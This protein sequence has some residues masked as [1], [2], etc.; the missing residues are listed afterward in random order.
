MFLYMLVLFR[1][2]QTFPVQGPVSAVVDSDK[3]TILGDTPNWPDEPTINIMT[4]PER[5]KAKVL[6]LIWERRQYEGSV[7][8]FSRNPTCST[9]NSPQDFGP[10]KAFTQNDVFGSA[11]DVDQG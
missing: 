11:G 1:S 9:Q 5:Q 8:G 2:L 7:E 6:E 3:T 10:S 4:Q